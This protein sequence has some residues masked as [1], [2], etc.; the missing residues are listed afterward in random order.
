[1]LER[2]IPAGKFIEL[3]PE[4]GQ[5]ASTK[6]ESLG[7]TITAYK[8]EHTMMPGIFVDTYLVEMADGVR[9]YHGTCS[10]GPET[11]KWMSTYPELKDLDVMII[12]CDMDFAAIYKQFTPRVMIRA[13]DF[14]TQ[15][16]P[17]PAIVYTDYPEG[18][19]VLE[20][21]QA[22]IYNP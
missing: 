12:D 9:W 1:M 10:S 21:G 16:K 13:H 19:L 15:I 11:L 20:N 5:T 22:W 6:I 7:L 14:M 4:S 2:G 17:A 8:M 3:S 18:E